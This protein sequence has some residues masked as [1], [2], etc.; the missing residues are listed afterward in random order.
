MK[1]SEFDDDEV[2]EIKKTNLKHGDLVVV[3]LPDGSSYGQYDQIAEFLNNKLSALGAAVLVMPRSVEF[4]VF[5][6]STAALF[7]KD[8]KHKNPEE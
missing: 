8:K 1:V 5:S 2:I 6:G 4:K 7:F 3:T